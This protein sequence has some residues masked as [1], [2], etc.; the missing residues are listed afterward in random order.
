MIFKLWHELTKIH[1]REY[2]PH[3]PSTF[4]TDFDPAQVGDDEH[5]IM[6][7]GLA[8]D[9]AGAKRVMDKNEVESALELEL[10]R[11]Q[12]KVNMRQR[13]IH[14]LM[15]LEGSTP[16][17]PVISKYLKE[18]KQPEMKLRGVYQRGMDDWS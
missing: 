4:R 15:R 13:F 18:Q 16:H 10:I 12:P 5:L 14:W 9:P 7:A 2:L 17:E 3:I 6:L 11:P 8:R 1:P